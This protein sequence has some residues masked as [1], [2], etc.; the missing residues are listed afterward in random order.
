MTKKK[1]LKILKTLAITSG[2]ALILYL[3]FMKI[4]LEPG[5]DTI[6]EIFIGLIAVSGT[7]FWVSLF[8]LL[9]CAYFCHPT[10]SE[11]IGEQAKRHQEMNQLLNALE[12]NQAKNDPWATRYNAH[13]C[14]Y[15]G[16]RKVR[17]AKWDDKRM[18]VAFWGVASDKIGKNYIE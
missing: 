13:S 14:P 12:R 2:I 5:F 8:F 1:Y 11:K 17:N 18:S 16:H 6:H 9:V 4:P 7:V 10:V 15:C 3:I